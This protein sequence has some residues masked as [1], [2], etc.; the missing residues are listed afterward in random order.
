MPFS[1]LIPNYNGVT[2][3]KE[4]LPSVIDAAEHSGEEYDIMVVDD[5]STDGSGACLQSKFPKVHVLRN[6]KNVGFGESVNR[7]MHSSKYKIVVLLN[8]DVLLDREFFKPLLRHFNDERIFGVVAK[9]LVE[10]D[11]I[12]KNESVTKYEFKDG[13]LNLIQPGI[14]DFEAKFD[15]VCTV[16]HACGGFSAFDKEKFL[17][18]GGLDDLYYPFYWEDVDIC[19]RAWKHGWWTLYEPMSVAHHRSHATINEISKIEYV[20]MLHVC[21][22]LLFTW[23][24][25]T[26]SELLV[27]HAHALNTYIKAAPEHFR[28]GFYEAL[29]KIEVVFL[30]RR[31]LISEEK[32]SDLKIF[33]LSANKPIDNNVI[34]L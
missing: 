4:Y 20:E 21:N 14:I 15:N 33:T 17:S 19:Y 16:A 13:F 25:L 32:C 12:I 31:A 10:Q 26:D 23:K 3:L 29:K 2:L 11:G 5:G 6:E 7:G 9:G 18:L 28:K 8:N 22:Q 1:I 34:V 30:R 27:Q 24:N